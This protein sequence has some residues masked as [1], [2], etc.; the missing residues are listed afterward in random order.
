MLSSAFAQKMVDHAKALDTA[1]RRLQSLSS[2]ILSGSKRAI[3][4]FHRGDDPKAHE[5]LSTARTKLKE[6]WAI[7][8][9]ESRIAQEG[10]WRAAQEEFAEADLLSQ[11]LASGKIGAV[12]DV[13][14]DP[15]IFLGG[16]SDLT[17]EL[18]RRAVLLASERKEASVE[19]LFE[20]VREVVSFLL[21]MDLTGT[22]RVKLDQ[23]KQ[24]LR[25]LEEIR[26]DLAMRRPYA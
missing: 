16:V 12:K 21:Q 3:F 5:E 11:Y 17:G 24:N 10:M 13:A 6:G 22:L 4:A 23:A 15:D 18:L 25:K 20:D 14:E 26:Y 1:R 9:K 2:E 19:K 8:K 7:V